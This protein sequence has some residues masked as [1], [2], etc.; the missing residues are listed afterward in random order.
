MMFLLQLARLGLFLALVH[1]L[2]AAAIGVMLAATANW[3]YALILIMPGLAIAAL[4]SWG[5]RTTTRAIRQRSKDRTARYGK[6][7]SG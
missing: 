2:I 3:G 5:I 4:S 1:S 7:A 6:V